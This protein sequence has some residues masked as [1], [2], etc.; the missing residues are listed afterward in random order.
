MSESLW[1]KSA[2]SP[3]ANVDSKQPSPSA[4]VCTNDHTYQLRQ[5]QS[6]NSVFILQPSQSRCGEDEIL[7]PSL[8]AIAQCTAT[9]ELILLDNVAS[10][11]MTS[12]FLKKSLPS[13]RGIDT[14]VGLGTNTTFSGKKV[15][16]RDAWYELWILTWCLGEYKDKNTIL[17]DAPFSTKEIDK[18]WKQQCAFEVLGR[19]W[20]P[21]PSALAMIWKSILSAATVSGVN[22][23]KSFDLKLLA[24][25]VDNDG[26]PW[27]FFMAVM[28]RLVSETDHLNDDSEGRTSSLGVLTADIIVKD[29][30]L[31][32]DRIVLWVGNVCLQRA[33][34]S[35][36]ANKEGILQEDFL[37]QW[38]N[39]LPE[40]WRMHAS[41]DLLKVQ[42]SS[43]TFL[44][45]RADN[46]AD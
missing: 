26:F 6:S 17:Q 23:V 30:H 29:I 12:R 41:M 9:L 13:Y 10:S 1:L 42:K 2:E 40:G 25:M 37:A 31:S 43:I 19:A 33:G 28:I 34:E 7:S 4:V 15:A 36:Q 3:S 16:A 14:D 38:H 11:A 18:I 39:L 5:V 35:E 27:A 44:L 32:R 45:N 20:L 22:L 24:E 21:T 46:H 8:L